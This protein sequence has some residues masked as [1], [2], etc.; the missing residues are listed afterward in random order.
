MF[1]NGSLFKTIF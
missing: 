1:A